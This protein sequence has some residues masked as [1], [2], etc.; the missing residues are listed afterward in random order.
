MLPDD[1]STDVVWNGKNIPSIQES[2][3][4]PENPYLITI[5]ANFGTNDINQIC[6]SLEI[7]QYITIVLQETRKIYFVN[8][9]DAIKF[10]KS[11]S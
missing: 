4:I 9:Q 1:P 3:D 7:Y 6:E 10:F 11:F 2:N 8:R 5:S